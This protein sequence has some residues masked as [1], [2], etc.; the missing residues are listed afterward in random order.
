MHSCA[1]SRGC[2]AGRLRAPARTLTG[3]A[4]R[5][6]ERATRALAVLTLIAGILAM[7]ALATGHHGATAS[8]VLTSVL[9]VS[10][11]VKRHVHAATV[12]AGA[13]VDGSQEI[14]TG[15]HDCDGACEGGEHALALLCVAV[16]LAA[17]ASV[18]VLRQRTGLLPRRTGPPSRAVTR[19]PAPPRTP[20]LVAELCISRT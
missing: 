3:M 17:G 8:P 11:A 2:P 9:N 15:Q 12:A 13:A 1:F 10:D 5:R 16:L 14:L 6:G 18:L 7:H 19:S 4:E 20:D